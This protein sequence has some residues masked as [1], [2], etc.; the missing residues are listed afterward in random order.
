MITALPLVKGLKALI[1]AGV[2]LGPHAE[3]FA[4]SLTSARTL[5]FLDLR[6]NGLEPEGAAALADALPG[7][8]LTS[9]DVSQ[10]RLPCKIQ[11]NEENE[12]CICVLCFCRVNHKSN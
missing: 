6:G 11:L 3:A 7:S 9:L 8:V 12:E 5:K 4:T 2:G 1:L 10:N